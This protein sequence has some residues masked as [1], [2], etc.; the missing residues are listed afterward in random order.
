MNKLTDSLA[1]CAILLVVLPGMI[2]VAPWCLWL[3][4]RDFLR[5]QA[6]DRQIR[7]SFR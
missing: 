3:M 2:L 7:E 6:E 1:F 4:Y 5:L